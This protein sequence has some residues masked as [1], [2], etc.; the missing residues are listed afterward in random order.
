MPNIHVI[1]ENS[2]GVNRG[3]YLDWMGNMLSDLVATTLLNEGAAILSALEDE[4]IENYAPSSRR[5]A[6][7]PTPEDNCYFLYVV[8]DLNNAV[9]MSDGIRWKPLGGQACIYK[10]PAPITITPGTSITNILRRL[11]PANLFKAGDSFIL[12]EIT[13]SKSGTSETMTIYTR[14]GKN[15]ISPPAANFDVELNS[16][17]VITGANQ[18][19]GTRIGY[20]FLN[21]TQLIKNGGGG[22]SSAYTGASGSSISTKTLI[23]GSSTVDP[24]YFSMDWQSSASVESIT[25]HNLSIAH[26]TG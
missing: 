6:D 19:F 4:T 12:E 16:G 9:Y 20:T 18:T 5:F 22:L 2:L 11:F 26:V 23:G 21:A 17:G 8:E 24:L 1:K 25:L 10:L 13:A 14:L 7:L 3:L 15:G